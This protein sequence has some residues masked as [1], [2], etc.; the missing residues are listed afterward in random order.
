M[1]RILARVAGRPL[2]RAE[3]QRLADGAAGGRD[4][5]IWNQA[6]L[7]IGAVMCRPRRPD[8]RSCPLASSCVWFAAGRPEP[9]PAAGS[10]A[11]SSPQST[12]DGSDRQGRGRLV[13]ALRS[14]P[15]PVDEL[16]PVMGWADDADRARRVVAGLVADG[17]IEQIDG[18]YRLPH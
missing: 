4:P 14:G 10:A 1:A 11:V 9:D 15:V 16:A 12:F 3:V 7:D 18:W 17:L 2:G 13:R 8:C 6:L 5:W